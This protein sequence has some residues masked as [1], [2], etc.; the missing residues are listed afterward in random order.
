M[1]NNKWPELCEQ[2]IA[3]ID[4]AQQHK[5]LTGEELTLVLIKMMGGKVLYFPR[6][7]VFK[8]FVRDQQIYKEFNGTNYK[9][10]CDKYDVSEPRIYQIIQEQRELRRS[11]EQTVIQFKMQL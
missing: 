7:T 4:D 2:M 9:A 11:K 8:N 5:K 6:A 10:L 3:T 1:Q